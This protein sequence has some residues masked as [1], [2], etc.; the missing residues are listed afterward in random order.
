M[1]VSGALLI[2]LAYTPA[3]FLYVQIALI[4]AV[5][6]V[7]KMPTPLISSYLTEILP[8][9]KAVPAVGVVIGGGS[10]LGQLLG[11]LIVGYMKSISSS[12]GPSFIVLG[13]AGVCGGGIL[14]AARSGGKPGLTIPHP[15][16]S[17]ES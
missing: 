2:C 13:V 17:K 15:E 3:H 12:F 1:V 16:L 9:R 11:P 5:G 14:L 7:L 10:F 6:F 8:L 4:L